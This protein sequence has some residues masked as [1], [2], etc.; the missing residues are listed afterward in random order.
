M[1]ERQ[2]ELFEQADN[3]V[4]DVGVIETSDE[5]SGIVTL[6]EA[7]EYVNIGRKQGVFCPC[8]RQYAKIYNRKLNK[9]MALAL[10]YMF[11]EYFKTANEWVH[12]EE[13]FI[14]RNQKCS[15][16]WA[17]LRFWGLIEENQEPPDPDKRTNG[18]WRITIRGK[19]FV[20]DTRVIVRKRIVL[21]N[22][23]LMDF[24]GDEINIIEALG[25]DFNYQ[26]LMN[27]VI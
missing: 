19:A 23:K 25:N 11:L 1:M 6:K 16:D 13:L 27:E 22:N 20:N 17:L 15:H 5:Q 18:L 8:C 12:V 24:D 21:Y 26:E 3:P 9:D 14:K 10:V 4:D 2:M 7:R